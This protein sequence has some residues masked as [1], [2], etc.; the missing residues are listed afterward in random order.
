[1]TIMLVLKYLALKLTTV[2][3][4]TLNYEITR[5][6]YCFSSRRIYPDFTS[7]LRSSVL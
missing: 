3:K 1:M 7:L 5:W 4:P 6:I 2:Q